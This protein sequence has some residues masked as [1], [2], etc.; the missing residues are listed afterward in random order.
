M[1]KLYLYLGK[2]LAFKEYI[3]LQKFYNEQS[4]LIYIY[5]YYNKINCVC[6]C[7][8]FN[9]SDELESFNLKNL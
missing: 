1:I 9:N 5:I 3:N 2:P 4:L 8:L 6:V 7:V